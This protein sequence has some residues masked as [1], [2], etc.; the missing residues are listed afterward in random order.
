MYNSRNKY[1]KNEIDD[2]VKE[3]GWTITNQ[4]DDK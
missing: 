4:L 2:Y 1:F 3:N